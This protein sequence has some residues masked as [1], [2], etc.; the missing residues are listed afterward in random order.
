MD[1]VDLEGADSEG[2]ILATED[3]DSSEAEDTEVTVT[4][5]LKMLLLT[6]STKWIR[7]TTA[8]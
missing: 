1:T 2:V 4:V 5:V 6:I 8:P 3:T 7:S